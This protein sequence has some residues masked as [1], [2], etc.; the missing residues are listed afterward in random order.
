[1]NLHL[2]PFPRPV[3]SLIADFPLEQSDRG[4][5]ARSPLLSL[6]SW[7]FATGKHGPPSMPLPRWP[8]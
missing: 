5:Q 6:L 4:W 2:A 1:M 8:M 7:A 3:T